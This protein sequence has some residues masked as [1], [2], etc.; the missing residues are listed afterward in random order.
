M[1]IIKVLSLLVFISPSFVHS[2]VNKLMREYES[3]MKGDESHSNTYWNSV[4]EMVA[5]INAIQK[6]TFEPSYQFRQRK[7]GAIT[8]LV[9]D[10]N[11]VVGDYP[12]SIVGNLEMKSYDADQSKLEGTVIWREGMPLT[13]NLPLESKV[14]VTFSINNVDA[15]N[16]F[17]DGDKQPVYIS[18]KWMNDSLAYNAAFILSDGPNRYFNINL[19]NAIP[20]GIGKDSTK[21]K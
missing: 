21:D 11:K 10:I 3:M 6:G 12:D 17:S 5:E 8:T 4:K 9:D 7:T 16:I 19:P 2:D 15:H 14:K 13:L 1:K 18:V 20:M